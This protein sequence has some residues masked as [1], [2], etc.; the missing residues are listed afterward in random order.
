MD[1]DLIYVALP[2]VVIVVMG[3]GLWLAIRERSGRGS[4]RS[5]REG[6]RMDPRTNGHARRGPRV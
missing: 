5:A 1:E 4:G 3:L 6:R 2:F